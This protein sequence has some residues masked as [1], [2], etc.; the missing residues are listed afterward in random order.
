MRSLTTTRLSHSYSNEGCSSATMSSIL[1]C[2]REIANLVFRGA[3]LDTPSDLQSSLINYT[4]DLRHVLERVRSLFPGVQHMRMHTAARINT[5]VLEKVPTEV[6]LGH[7]HGICM[8]IVSLKSDVAIV[9]N[10][11][12]D[13]VALPSCVLHLIEW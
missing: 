7:E 1:F 2:R 8:T 4:R 11:N 9:Q 10:S 3:K 13:L 12:R 5:P 6:S